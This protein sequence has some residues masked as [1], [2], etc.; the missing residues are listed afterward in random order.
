MSLNK[1]TFKTNLLVSFLILALLLPYG[2]KLSHTLEFHRIVECGHSETHIHEFRFHSELLDYCLQPITF[3][4]FA[5]ESEPNIFRAGQ[6]VISSTEQLQT[7]TFHDL[8]SRG[9]PFVVI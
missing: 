4:T 9:P 8:A 2:L 3:L 5:T 1:N 6:K 7:Q